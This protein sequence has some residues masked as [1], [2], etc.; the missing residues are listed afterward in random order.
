M[1]RRKWIVVGKDFSSGAA[2]AVERAVEL[3][4]ET[5]ASVACVHAYEDPPGTPLLNDPS[6][7]MMA[8]LEQSV[9]ATRRRYPTVPV[10]CFVRRGPAW[11]KLS[12][13]AGE[14]GAEL[15]VVGAS[16]QHG[17]AHPSFPRSV[18]TRAAPTSHRPVMVVPAHADE[19]DPPGA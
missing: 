11:D 1:Q 13:V 8:D 6:A 18:T 2:R 17:R 14:L 12:N 7:A 15:I 4:S 19:A 9:A 5:G 10:E 3:A 16:G